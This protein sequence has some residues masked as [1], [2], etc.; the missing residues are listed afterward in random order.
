[1]VIVLI[2]MVTQNVFVQISL[3]VFVSLLTLLK[4]LYVGPKSINPKTTENQ[5]GTV[6]AQIAAFGTPIHTK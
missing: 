1:M 3:V 5:S 4:S 2:N 6:L